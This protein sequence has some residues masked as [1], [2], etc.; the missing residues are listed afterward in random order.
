MS[1]G[2]ESRGENSSRRVLTLALGAK[3]RMRGMH[4]EDLAFAARRPLFCE[5]QTHAREGLTEM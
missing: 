1:T 4:G 3:E 5:G 2:W